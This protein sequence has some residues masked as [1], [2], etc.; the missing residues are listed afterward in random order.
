MAGLRVDGPETG[1]VIVAMALAGVLML[2][3]AQPVAARDDHG[4]VVPE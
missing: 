2:S 4:G 3:K 1:V